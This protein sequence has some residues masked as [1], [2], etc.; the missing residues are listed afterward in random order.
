M[1]VAHRRQAAHIS[2]LSEKWLEPTPAGAQV[3]A[4]LIWQTMMNNCI[5]Q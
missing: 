4:N 3:I 5:A 2:A 1:P